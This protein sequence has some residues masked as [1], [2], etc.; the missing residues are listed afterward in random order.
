M[1]IIVTRMIIIVRDFEVGH[2]VKLLILRRR[3]QTGFLKWVLNLLSFLQRIGS[4]VI[5]QNLTAC[6]IHSWSGVR[7]MALSFFQFLDLLFSDQMSNISIPPSWY[8]FTHLLAHKQLLVDSQ[9]ISSQ[10]WVSIEIYLKSHWKEWQHISD[11]CAAS[12]VAYIMAFT[13]FLWILP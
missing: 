9:G 6:C 10:V 8:H 2:K 3:N 13:W 4:F 5:V 12:C 1:Y 7:M 11:L